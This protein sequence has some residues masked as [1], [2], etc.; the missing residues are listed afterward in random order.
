MNKVIFFIKQKGSSKLL[1]GYSLNG[2]LF[3]IRQKPIK[4]RLPSHHIGRYFI[5]KKSK[6]FTGCTESDKPKYVDK[7]LLNWLDDNVILPS[8]TIPFPEEQIVQQPVVHSE[9]FNELKTLIKKMN[10]ELLRQYCLE[11]YKIGFEIGK[12]NAQY[13]DF[14]EWFNQKFN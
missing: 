13:V 4:D 7:D 12:R 8:P 14:T 9:E 5:Y 2:E 3:E 10:K 6:Q 11:A 1:E